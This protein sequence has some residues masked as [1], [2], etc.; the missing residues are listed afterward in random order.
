[1]P[2]VCPFTPKVAVGPGFLQVLAEAL[3][4]SGTRHLNLENN[5]IGDEGGEVQ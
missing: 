5:D 3:Q 4:T 1:M 2:Q